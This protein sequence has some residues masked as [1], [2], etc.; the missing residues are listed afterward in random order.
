MGD[1]TA[2]RKRVL[3]INDTQEILELFDAFLTDEMGLETVL[4]SY[5]PNELA[6]IVEVAPD[7][8]IVDFILDGREYLGWQLIQKLRMSRETQDIPIVACT[9]ATKAVREEE[10]Y[11][12]EQGIAV[13]LK[14]FK[15]DQLELVVRKALERPPGRGSAELPRSENQSPEGGS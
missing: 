8:I 11:L 6:Q 12:L 7:L 10:G 1:Q 14:P 2:G 4:M 3:V 13:I 9:G 15:I 5:A